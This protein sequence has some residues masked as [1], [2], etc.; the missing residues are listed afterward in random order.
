MELA[1]GAVGG[2]RESFAVTNSCP[3]WDAPLINVAK[4]RQITIR[5][6][7][8]IRYWL[9][10]FAGRTCSILITTTTFLL[11]RPFERSNFIAHRHYFSNG[12]TRARQGR[13]PGLWNTQ[14]FRRVLSASVRRRT[15]ADHRLLPAGIARRRPVSTMSH[16]GVEISSAAPHS[17]SFSSAHEGFRLGCGLAACCRRGT[18]EE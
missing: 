6:R 15:K 9:F 3:P 13:E 1:V 5:R 4:A 12:C 18:G 14:T 8:P 17:E 7:L 11:G 2:L 16:A 10:P